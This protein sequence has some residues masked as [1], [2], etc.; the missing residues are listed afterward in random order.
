MS[1]KYND[2][3][4]S[5]DRSLGESIRLNSFAAVPVIPRDRLYKIREARTRE[6]IAVCVDTSTPRH[7][8]IGQVVRD[9]W[10]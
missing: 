4:N 10:A 6:D 1:K 5:F 3:R 7:T 9:A 8:A 2:T